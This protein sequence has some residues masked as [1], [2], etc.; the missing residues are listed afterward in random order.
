MMKDTQKMA[1]DSLREISKVPDYDEEQKNNMN[2][3]LKML[4][5]V[6]PNIW[7][8]MDLLDRTKI[9]YYV[10]FQI[11][12]HLNN[13]GMGNKYGTVTV[14][15]ENGVVTFVR[16]EESSKINEKLIVEPVDIKDILIDNKE[17]S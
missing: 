1:D 13:I 15:I 5:D 3:F 7:V 2:V 17:L 16:G 4:K 12:R 10:I 9:N 8:L 14:Q 11:I 6:R